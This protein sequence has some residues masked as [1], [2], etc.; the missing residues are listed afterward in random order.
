MNVN[1]IKDK[2]SQILNNPD[3]QNKLNDAKNQVEDFVKSGKGK[4]ALDKIE[5]FVEEKTDGK[6]IFGFGKKD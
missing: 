1:D 5:G 4:E 6:G 2:A 3:L